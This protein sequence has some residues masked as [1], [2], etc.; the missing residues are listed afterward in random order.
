MCVSPRK[1]VKKLPKAQR[2]I[3]SHTFFHVHVAR[4][5]HL[6]ADHPRTCLVLLSVLMDHM[7]RS[8]FLHCLPQVDMDL[9]NLW[10]PHW[11][12][13]KN[14][15]NWGMFCH[16]RPA[17]SMAFHVSSFVQW[18]STTACKPISSRWSSLRKSA[19]A[20]GGEV[21]GGEV[22]HCRARTL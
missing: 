2:P 8:S 6:C 18:S 1:Y 19:H 5:K 20:T 11:Q 3:G 22:S 21:S 13:W 17:T 15:G 14:V 9:L 7:M 4:D 16:C 10:D 12:Y